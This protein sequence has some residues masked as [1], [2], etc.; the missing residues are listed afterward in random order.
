MV[1]GAQEREAAKA[2]FSSAEAQSAHASKTFEPADDYAAAAAASAPGEAGEAE[3]AGEEA[4]PKATAAPTQ[5]QMVAIKAGEGL[6][7][8]ACG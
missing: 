8:A 7:W 6:G 2:A 1:G 3:A 5:D 4:A